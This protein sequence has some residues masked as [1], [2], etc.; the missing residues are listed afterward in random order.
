MKSVRLDSLLN[1]NDNFDLI[2]ID[3]QGVEKE[4]LEGL[5]SL[6]TKANYIYSEVNKEQVYQ[7]CTIVK[8]L[9]LFLNQFGFKRVVTKWVQGAGWGD[10]LYIMSP[11]TKYL[12]FGKYLTLKFLYFDIRDIVQSKLNRKS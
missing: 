6:I 9:D 12:I 11:N 1:E 10:A 7:N 8:D 3:V 2:N 5:G 4:A